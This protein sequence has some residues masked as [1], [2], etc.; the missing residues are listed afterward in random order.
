MLF[1]YLHFISINPCAGDPPTV[2]GVPLLRF[3]WEPVID[4]FGAV[5]SSYFQSHGDS[6]NAKFEV[7]GHETS[8]IVDD[9][10]VHGDSPFLNI[11]LEIVLALQRLVD[12]SMV[13]SQL[14]RDCNSFIWKSKK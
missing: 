2:E 10:V 13:S 3:F 9:Q 5:A 8:V 11:I 12:S 14:C 7:A 1:R 4:L 6:V